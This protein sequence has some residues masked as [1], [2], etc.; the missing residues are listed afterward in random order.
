MKKNDPTKHWA[1][2]RR[3][4][5]ACLCNLVHRIL[6][7]FQCMWKNCSSVHCIFHEVWEI[8]YF[9]LKNRMNFGSDKSKSLFKWW[10][11]PSWFYQ[12]I[13]YV[14]AIPPDE[15]R[16]GSLLSDEFDSLSW[17]GMWLHPAE[18]I[19]IWVG[20][21]TEWKPS[22]MKCTLPGRFFSCFTF[23]S[24]LE[25]LIVILSALNLISKSS[26]E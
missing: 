22:I 12:I 9:V 3:F 26:I 14:V 20:P 13:K 1:I 4:F 7:V 5:I 2:N 19:A 6:R 24:L 23:E 11:L 21:S 25:T 8:E 18:R 16:E 15:F 17:C 10:L